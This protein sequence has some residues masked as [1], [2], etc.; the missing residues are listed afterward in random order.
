[1]RRLNGKRETLSPRSDIKHCFSKAQ[2]A[3]EGDSHGVANE[4]NQPTSPQSRKLTLWVRIGIYSLFVLSG[5]AVATLLGR[6]YY[7]RGGQSKWLATLVQLAGFPILLPY[8]FI[9]IK[10]FKTKTNHTTTS[11]TTNSIQSKKPSTLLVTSI[12]LVLG[13]M[14]AAACYLYSV[15][16][17]YLPVSTYSIICASQLGFNAFFSFFLNS[18]KF[19]PYIINSLVLLTIS[20]VL[21]VF[22]PNSEESSKVSK[23]KYALGFVCT[24]G[25][26]AGYG[27][28]LPL[29]QFFMNKVLK[30]E[31][32][33]VVMDVIVFQSLV[34]TVAILVGLFASSEW[35]TLREE[36]NEFELGKVSYV[37]TLSWTAI[38]WQVLSIGIVGLIL[39]VSALFSNVIGVLGLPIVPVM[40]V[41]FFHEKMD[42]I[43]AMAMV[44]AI[45]GFVSYAYQ[46]YLD[47]HS[48]KNDN[49]IR[50]SQSNGSPERVKEL[51]G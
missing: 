44:L 41:F 43:K 37:M 16:L 40:A 15:G 14:V 29:T 30:K 19:T 13:L 24:V 12:Y 32:F 9:P 10:R 51:N 11:T 23:G 8:Y 6:L 36:M 31:S 25:A 22:E 1:M 28:I 27:L 2:E 49:P 21:L 34:A 7:E 42:G 35:S 48:S 39:E 46:N 5:Q 47:N 38:A 45:W 33:S 17:M 50:N 20:S 26:S 4:S 18:Q 3:N